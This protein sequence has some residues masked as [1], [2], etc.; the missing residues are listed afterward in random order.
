MKNILFSL[1]IPEIAK[2]A[3][4]F[5]RKSYKKKVVLF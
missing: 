5:K 2:I 4:Y 3:Q 1:T